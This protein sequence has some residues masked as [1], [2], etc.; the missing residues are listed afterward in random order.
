MWELETLASNS[1]AELGKKIK[2]FL[3]KK[4]LTKGNFEIEY[5]ISP[6]YAYTAMIIYNKEKEE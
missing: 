1:H 4:S 2:D 5:A 3:N 6:T